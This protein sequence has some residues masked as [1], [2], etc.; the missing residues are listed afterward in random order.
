M[1][2]G[3]GWARRVTKQNLQSFAQ[4]L[5]RLQDKGISPSTKGAKTPSIAK[6]VVSSPF[7]G[8]NFRFTSRFAAPKVKK[9]MLMWSPGVQQQSL[10][11]EGRCSGAENCRRLMHRRH[12]GARTQLVVCG[13][14]R[15]SEKTSTRSTRL[16][17]F[18]MIF[19]AH[20]PGTSSR[21]SLTRRP[22]TF[23]FM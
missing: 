21:R 18:G 2:D 16:L 4:Y 22:R 3:Q 5:R 6:S 1:K 23:R 20:F 10:V 17:T 15:L 13:L 8:K 7:Q 9:N 19:L 11:S 14:F 12:Q